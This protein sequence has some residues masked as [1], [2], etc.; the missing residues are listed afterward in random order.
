M[1]AE[2]KE[3]VQSPEAKEKKTR[4]GEEQGGRQAE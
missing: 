2:Q 3:G 1:S 4:I